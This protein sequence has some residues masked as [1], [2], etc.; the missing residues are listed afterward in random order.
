LWAFSILLY[1]CFFEYTIF[2]S[3][4]GDFSIVVQSNWWWREWRDVNRLLESSCFGL[5]PPLVLWNWHLVSTHF[6]INSHFKVQMFSM[7]GWHITFLMITHDYT[8]LV[9]VAADLRICIWHRDALVIDTNYC[10]GRWMGGSDKATT[11]VTK[12]RR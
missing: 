5:S 6:Y 10:V 9:I 12:S 1:Q 2:F 7:D 3:S 11:N 4:V 8:S